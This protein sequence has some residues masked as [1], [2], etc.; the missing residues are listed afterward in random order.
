MKHLNPKEAH[1]FLH[2]NPEA[3]LVDCRSEMEYLFVGHPAGAHHVAW[4]DGP[5]W[6]INPHFVGE[7]Q[8][9]ASHDRPVVLI[10][11][12]GQRSVDAGIS[13]EKSGF[14]DTINVLEGFEGPLD[15]QHQRSKISGWRFHGL[16]WEQC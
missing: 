3:V 8:K 13:L 6:T 15:E 14:S 11:R 9:I 12:R 5:D 1:D 2:R 10:C 4:N 16:P 7:V